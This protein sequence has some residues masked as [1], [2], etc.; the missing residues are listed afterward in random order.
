M[1]RLQDKLRNK[2]LFTLALEIKICGFQYSLANY[3]AYTSVTLQKENTSL[4]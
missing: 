1:P 3:F 2:S 4:R